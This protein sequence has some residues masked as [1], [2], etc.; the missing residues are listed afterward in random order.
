MCRRVSAMLVAAATLCTPASAFAQ[1]AGDDQY[2]DPFAGRGQEQAEGE[3]D[4]TGGDGAGT[5]APA[6]A[7]T[8]TE[9]TA[10]EPIATVAGT[11]PRTGA[12]SAWVALVGL[13]LVAAGA[14]LRRTART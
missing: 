13:L 1:S 14:G 12:E 11:L 10:A 6:P 4:G 9:S 8:P 5:T 7:A 2:R 3:S